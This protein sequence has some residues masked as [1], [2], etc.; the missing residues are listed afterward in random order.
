MPSEV[1]TCSSGSS[2]QS[3]SSKGGVRASSHSGLQCYLVAEPT[4]ATHETVACAFFFGVIVIGFAVLLVHFFPLLACHSAC[5][6][7][8]F[9][10]PCVDVCLLPCCVLRAFDSSI[11]F[12]AGARPHARADTGE[13]RDHVPA[14]QAG[15]A[16]PVAE[17]R[18]QCQG[19]PSGTGHALRVQLVEGPCHMNSCCC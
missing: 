3:F 19:L 8:W 12:I 1:S 2:T 7:G 11:M 15:T 4:A 16:T 18:A 14:T 5:L 13:R 6:S 10:S 17:L 9:C